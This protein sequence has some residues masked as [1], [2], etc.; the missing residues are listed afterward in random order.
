MLTY[1][2]R[3][4]DYVA[5]CIFTCGLA[6]VLRSAAEV[7]AATVQRMLA[8][9]RRFY[10]RYPED[11]KTVQQI[12]VHL[13]D[14]EQSEEGGGVVL[15]SGGVLTVRRFQMLGLMLGSGSGMEALHW[16]LET[17]WE[18]PPG[19]GP[20]LS[21]AFL[22]AVDAQQNAFETN[23]VYWVLHESIYCE[24]GGAS[25]WAAARAVAD[26]G[27]FDAVG[28]A[29]KGLPVSFT[30]EMVFPWMG[31]DF[32]RLRPLQRVATELAARAWDRQLYDRQRLKDVAQKVPIAALVSYD[33]IYVER[34]FSEEVAELLGKEACKLWVTNEFQ[35][36]GLR[37]DGER[38]FETLLKMTDD[39][40][41]LPS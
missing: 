37:D 20:E 25:N 10:A 36:S 14:A 23:P 38:V 28:N 24:A 27:E 8:R 30:G 1:L 19:D 34:R 31:E 32:K 11:I 18:E 5:R 40:I 41:S 3:F 39:E 9:N 16:M 6:P 17:A 7:Y 21:T 13:A 12:V 15:P 29:E 33:D 26:S 22:H 2:S 35:H 4:S